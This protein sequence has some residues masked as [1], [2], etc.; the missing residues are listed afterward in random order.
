M[1]RGIETVG[2]GSLEPHGRNAYVCRVSALGCEI[3]GCGRW[4]CEAVCFSFFIFIFS[5]CTGQRSTGAPGV[6]WCVTARWRG[7]ARWN[8]VLSVHMCVK[9]QLLDVRFTAVGGGYVRRSVFFFFFLLFSSC[10]G[11]RSTGAPGVGWC[12]GVRWRGW[13]RW[14]RVLSV[15]MC[16]KFQLLDVR[17]TAVGD[18]YVKRSVFHFSIFFFRHAR[19]RGQLAHGWRDGAWDSDGVAGLVGTARSQCI[20]VLNLIVWVSSVWLWEMDM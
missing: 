20:C 4:L 8:R 16:V 11:Q 7:W 5:S 3:Y 6:G 14:N 12:V 18:G 19:G 17:F 9:F 1:V 13:A 2:L 15:H 10:T